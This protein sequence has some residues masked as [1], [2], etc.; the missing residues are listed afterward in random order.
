MKADV[1]HPAS[2]PWTRNG[3]LLALSLLCLTAFFNSADRQIISILIEPIKAEFGTSDTAIGLLT[4]S[5]FALFYCLASLPLARLADKHPRRFVIAACLGGWSLLT[6]LGA[7]AANIGQLAAT[8]IGVALGE[9]GS[10]PASYASIADL[11]PLAH[12]A[13]ALAAFAASMSLGIGATLSIGGWLVESHGW[14]TTLVVLA[15][16]G[17]LLSLVVLL[18]FREPERGMADG[19]APAAADASFTVKQVL[20]Y[21]WR[22]RSYRYAVLVVGLGGINGYG[23]LFWGPSYMIRVH[24]MSTATVGLIF[25]LIS[26]A[27]LIA[28]QFV[29]GIFADRAGQRD[30]R[31]YMWYAAAGCLLGAPFGLLF[32]FAAGTK[33][34]IVG[35]GFMSF[36]MGSHYMCATVIAQTLVPPRMR[37]M[38]ATILTLTLSISGMGVAPLLIGGLSDLLTPVY[39]MEAIRYSL[40]AASL[41]LA[42]GGLSALAATRTLREDLAL[43]GAEQ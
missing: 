35:F 36:L 11:Y 17:L 18:L 34:A 1:Q 43:L 30:I 23:M 8:R 38:S 6:G 5:A 42:L 2:P 21:L 3:R 26:M 37:A 27:S 9:A 28:G 41:C 25:G 16:P 13:K 40:T 32:A 31:A 14:R 24:G 20:S 10:G 15:L 19:I 29:V 39:G 22:M 33:L 7:V 12:R 4:G